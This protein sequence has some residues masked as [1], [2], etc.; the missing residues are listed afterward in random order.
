MD[1]S[2][3]KNCSDKVDKVEMKLPSTCSGTDYRYLFSNK[4]GMM[5]NSVFL[6]VMM[7]CVFQ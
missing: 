3:E 1:W 4:L 2:D 7:D 6:G 5:H